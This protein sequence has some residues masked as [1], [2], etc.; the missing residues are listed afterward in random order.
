MVRVNVERRLEVLVSLGVHPALDGFHAHAVSEFGIV[1]VVV[2]LLAEAGH[3]DAALPDPLGPLLGLLRLP[4]Q[5]QALLSLREELKGDEVVRPDPQCVLEILDC[6]TLL[7][8]RV[9]EPGADRQSVHVVRV[10]FEAVPDQ[11][12]RLVGPSRLQGQAACEGDHFRVVRPV[13]HELRDVRCRAVRLVQIH[14]RAS[15]TEPAHPGVSPRG[16]SPQSLVVA[17]DGICEFQ[18]VMVHYTQHVP[19][20]AVAGLEPR[21]PGACRRHACRRP[22]SGRSGR[23]A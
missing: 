18:A 13:P 9:T 10:R 4:I 2:D 19:R 1:R 12:G 17:Q 3:Q 7:A 14:D 23:A 15:P 21:P 6:E 16:R 20:P 11:S 8:G 22:R 5:S